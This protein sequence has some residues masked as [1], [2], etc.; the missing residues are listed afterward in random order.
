MQ[1]RHTPSESGYM[2]GEVSQLD[3]LTI[4]LV[5]E[6]LNFRQGRY[7]FE[8]KLFNIRTVYLT[9]GI[10]STQNVTHTLHCD[11]HLFWGKQTNNW[12]SKQVW[13]VLKYM[14]INQ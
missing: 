4:E 5:K 13:E 11:R 9:N 12:L 6:E 1:I 14:F 8:E 2:H 7:V 3:Q 10:N